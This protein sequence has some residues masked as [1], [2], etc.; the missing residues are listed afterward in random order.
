MN[1]HASIHKRRVND[2]GHV[3]DMT[4]KKSLSYSLSHEK[5]ACGLGGGAKCD[6]H[7]RENL[8]GLK[9]GV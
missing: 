4:E 8:Y 7:D 3:T 1:I 6:R 9:T 5:T 2:S